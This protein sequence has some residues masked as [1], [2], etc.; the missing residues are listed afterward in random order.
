MNMIRDRLIQ[1]IAFS[2]ELRTHISPQNHP[3]ITTSPPPP[4]PTMRRLPFIL[5]TRSFST[6]PT[7]KPSTC[8]QSSSLK[9]RDSPNH[10]SKLHSQPWC[11]PSPATA[12]FSP[13]GNNNP[14]QQ[15]SASSQ[16]WAVSTT[17]IYPS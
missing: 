9:S 4:P 6:N 2:N 17:A 7:K 8:K 11:T 5:F 1:I 16:Q 13:N 3:L 10:S 12:T 14:P 15:P